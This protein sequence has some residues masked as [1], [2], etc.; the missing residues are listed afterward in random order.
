MDAA[1]FRTA[2][3]RIGL[4]AAAA[5]AFTDS[6]VDTLEGLLFFT[7]KETKEMVSAL[8]KQYSADN[9]IHFS[10][11]FAI[12]LSIVCWY[13]RRQRTMGIEADAATINMA[14]VD[15]AKEQKQ[16]ED[17]RREHV[18]DVKTI[19]KMVKWSDW[20]NFEA[21]FDTW[22]MNKRGVTDAPLAYVTREQVA[23]GDPNA[24][25]ETMEER[26]IALT[27]HGTESYTSDNH[28]VFEELISLVSTFTIA[29]NEIKGLTRTRNG[30]EAWNRLKEKFNGAIGADRRMNRARNTLNTAKYDGK[31]RGVTLDKVVAKFRDAF[32]TLSRPEVNE[33]VSNKE[34]ISK[35]LD[36]IKVDWLKTHVAVIKSQPQTYDTFDA[37]AAHLV[38]MDDQNKPSRYTSSD[39]DISQL[40]TERNGGGGSRGNGRGGGKGKRGG[41]GGGNEKKK[42][43]KYS[44]FLPKDQW[45]ALSDEE[46]ARRTAAR[47]ARGEGRN[48]EQVETEEQPADDNN[49]TNAGANN[50]N[51]GDQFGRNAHRE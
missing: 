42:R 35:F 3:T 1:A 50:G 44:D 18:E 37:V 25:Y 33:P 40:G 15:A 45:N 20:P 13:F 2:L 36:A 16:I 26:M 47:R 43:G 39:R 27:P 8:Q 11:I 48:V 30:R 4:N 14:L 29:H 10:H 21:A 31:S 17:N 32:D 28:A 38:S 7:P 49:G 6:G 41:R 19:E 23:V 24:H 34:Q 9:N 51:A 22:L 46:K 12:R 5:Q